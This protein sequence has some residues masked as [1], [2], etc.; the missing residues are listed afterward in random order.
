MIT[1]RVVAACACSPSTFVELLQMRLCEW[2]QKQAAS[3]PLISRVL[4]TA[5]RVS[6]GHPA[7]VL[8]V[9]AR[10]LVLVQPLFPLLN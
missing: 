3:S 4:A 6:L 5:R 9:V 10:M 1:R 7:L 2:W 8:V